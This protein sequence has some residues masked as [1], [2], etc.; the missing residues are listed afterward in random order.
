MLNP[1][2]FHD[3]QRY[4]NLSST[5][6]RFASFANRQVPRYNSWNVCI[7]SE[8]VDAL[9]VDWSGEANYGNPPWQII[10]RVLAHIRRLRVSAVLVLSAGRDRFGGRFCAKNGS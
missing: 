7:A 6:D 5:V 10:G 3:I 2:Y 8:A 1:K 9:S 4:F